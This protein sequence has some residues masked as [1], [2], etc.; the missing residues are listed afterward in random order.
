MSD[1]FFDR[2]EY[3]ETETPDLTGVS[4]QEILPKNCVVLTLRISATTFQKT[5]S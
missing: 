3:E 1:L 2:S 4:K 5:F